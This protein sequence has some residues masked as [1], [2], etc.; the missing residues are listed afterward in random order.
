MKLNGSLIIIIIF[1]NKYINNDHNKPK[2][3]NYNYEAIDIGPDSLVTSD[4]CTPPPP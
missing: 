2:Y 1:H 4:I 3:H